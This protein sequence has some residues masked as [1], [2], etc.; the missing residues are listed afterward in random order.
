VRIELERD[1]LELVVDALHVFEHRL[2]RLHTRNSGR[3]ARLS[4]ALAD[5]I[6]QG[7]R[8]V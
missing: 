5:A 2:L 7:K 6:E 8:T 1:E 4:S 3:I